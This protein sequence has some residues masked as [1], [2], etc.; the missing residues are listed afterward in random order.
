[1]TQDEELLYLRKVVRDA[2]PYV[3]DEY[4]REYPHCEDNECTCWQNDLRVLV[5]E[6]TEIAKEV[7]DE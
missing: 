3:R 7:G 5:Y 1:M 6:M 2:L 4:Y